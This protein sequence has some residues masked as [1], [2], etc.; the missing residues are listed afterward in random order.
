MKRAFTSFCW[1]LLLMLGFASCALAEPRFPPPEFE[2]GHQLPVT[3]V[4]AARSLSGRVRMWRC[5]PS[6]L[7]FRAG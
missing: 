1:R 2:T 6:A 3:Q 7:A 4:P 5:W